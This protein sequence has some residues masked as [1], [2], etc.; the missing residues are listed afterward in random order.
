MVQQ[1]AERP[2][3]LCPGPFLYHGDVDT[4]CASVHALG[5]AAFRSMAA[6]VGSLENSEA[7]SVT[8]FELALT[9]FACTIWKTVA[10]W[11][12]YEISTVSPD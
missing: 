8:V 6:N 5:P 10:P 7:W 4:T 1:C 2:Q 12:E 9:T 3:T 11:I